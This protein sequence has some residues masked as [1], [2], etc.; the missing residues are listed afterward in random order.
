MSAAL[1]DPAAMTALA[2]AAAAAFAAFLFARAVL[3]KL[4]DFTAFTGFVADY[5][6]LPETLVKPA[7]VALI[8]A[9]VA[10][11]LAVMVP[12]ARGFGL[13]LGAAMLL[14]YALAMGINV[15]RGRRHIECGCGGAVQPITPALLARNGVLAALLLASAAMPATA[16]AWTDAA[17]AIAA[18]LIFFSGYLMADQLLSNAAYLVRREQGKMQ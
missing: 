18:A 13:V 10:V 3:H 8:A 5:R 1:S 9:E 6:L 11:V 17:A 14:G 4:W 15:A 7:S 16:L 2:S 12:G